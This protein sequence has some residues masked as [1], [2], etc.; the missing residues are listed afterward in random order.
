[1]LLGLVYYLGGGFQWAGLEER[2]RMFII[3]CGCALSL[4]K[5]PLT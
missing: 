1:M 4:L 5:H 3:L 2:R